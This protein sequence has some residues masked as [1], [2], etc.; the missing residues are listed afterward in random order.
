V[1]VFDVLNV[2]EAW[3]IEDNGKPDKVIYDDNGKQ[4]TP[5]K[6]F[7]ANL[8]QTPTHNYREK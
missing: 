5:Y 4:L 7:Q 8:F 3:I 6:R 1:V 2:L